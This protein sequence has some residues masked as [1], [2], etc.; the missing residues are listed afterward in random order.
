MPIG[1]YH[2]PEEN[3]VLQAQK[4]NDRDH[5]PG[6][7]PNIHANQISGFDNLRIEPMSK[8]NVKVNSYDKR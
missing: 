5:R 3:M 8:A 7:G 4:K 2:K 6:V 1:I